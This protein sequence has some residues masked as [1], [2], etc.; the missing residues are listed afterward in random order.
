MRCENEESGH[1]WLFSDFP[2]MSANA[3]YAQYLGLALKEIGYDV[4]I[5]SPGDIE[6]CEYDEKENEYS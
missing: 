3:N 1:I 6:K 4:T 2:H 5:I